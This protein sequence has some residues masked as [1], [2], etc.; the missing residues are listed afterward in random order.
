[1]LNTDLHNTN[2]VRKISLKKFKLNWYK[3]IDTNKKVPISIMNDI[4]Q[5]I[6]ANQFNFS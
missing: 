5:D 4:Y 6:L 2:V 3:N 1:M